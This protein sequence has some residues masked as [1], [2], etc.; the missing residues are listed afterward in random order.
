[1][2]RKFTDHMTEIE[3]YYSQRDIELQKQ[4]QENRDNM[5]AINTRL[6]SIEGRMES[7]ESKLD[8][9]INRLNG[10]IGVA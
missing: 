2:D 1:M 5:A 3:E 4:I 9:I 6:E 7:V 10:D 8:T